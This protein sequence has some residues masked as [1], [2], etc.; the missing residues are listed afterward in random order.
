MAQK[1]S[2]EDLGEPALKVAGFQLWIHGAAMLPGTSSSAMLDPVEP[3]LRVSLEAVDALGHIRA[4]VEI[5]PDPL[6]QSHERSIRSA[7]AS[8]SPA[9]RY[10]P[11]PASRLRWPAA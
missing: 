5:S 11:G 9:S 1:P 7:V 2:P 10:P 6:A 8:T 4:Q 3:E